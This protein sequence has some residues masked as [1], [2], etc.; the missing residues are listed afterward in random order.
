MSTAASSTATPW[1]ELG[2]RVVRGADYFVALARNWMAPVSLHRQAEG[3][4][5][6]ERIEQ[7]N[8]RMRAR[9]EGRS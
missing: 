3:E 4:R 5:H 9:M 2:S 6:G 7:Q 8:A 1:D